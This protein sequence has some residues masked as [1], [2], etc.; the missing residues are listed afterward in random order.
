MPKLTKLKSVLYKWAVQYD[1]PSGATVTSPRGVGGA[2]T[3]STKK[4]TKEY[5]N[6]IYY[7]R[8]ILKNPDITD[9]FKTRD[10]LRKYISSKI[11][12]SDEV[13][14]DRIISI[15]TQQN[16]NESAEK[17]SK[18]LDANTITF[19]RNLE[20]S[21]LNLPN[22]SNLNEQEQKLEKVIDSFLTLEKYIDDIEELNSNNILLTLE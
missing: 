19:I 5:S 18:P 22:S 1:I 17:K 2:D 13:L 10:E 20:Q 8:R 16:E 11:N 15:A 4:I 21:I 14:I 6:I 12:M 9:N 7:I 3:Y